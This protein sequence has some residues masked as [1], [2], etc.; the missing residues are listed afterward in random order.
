[1]QTLIQ[2]LRYGARMLRKNP[3]F[4]LIAVLTLALGIG[5]NTAIFSVVNAVLLRPLP[6]R[7]PERLAQIWEKKRDSGNNVISPDNFLDWQKQAKSFEGLSIYDVWLPAISTAGKTEQIVGISASANFFS[8]LG[9]TPQLGRTFAPDEEKAGKDRVV[10]ISHS[11]WE[12]RLG[13]K[14]DV[15]GEKLTLD[16]SSYTIVG[17]LRVG[18]GDHPIK[19]RR[20]SRKY[21]D[22]KCP[23]RGG[24]AGDHPNFAIAF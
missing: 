10:V 16:Q 17:V 13:G 14:A 8:L 11:F 21:T 24:P 18:A 23:Y 3:G 4:T 19:Y 22:F 6:Y 9:V 15:I 1:M 2:D 7:E 12:N 5:A 20:S